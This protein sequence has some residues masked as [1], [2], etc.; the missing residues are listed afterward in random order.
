MFSLLSVKAKG[1]ETG[2]ILS[3]TD[4]SIYS[5]VLCKLIWEVKEIDDHPEDKVKGGQR[6]EMKR[7]V[8]AP[9]ESWSPDSFCYSLP[10]GLLLPLETV[11]SHSL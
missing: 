8:K 7:L 5:M 1:T 9:H 6:K 10:H 11:F 4:G 2:I 3:F